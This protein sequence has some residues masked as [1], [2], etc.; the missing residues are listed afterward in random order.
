[1]FVTGDTLDEEA[2]IFL[3]KTRALCIGK[4]FVPEEITSVVRKAALRPIAS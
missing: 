4:P 1:V 3:K 2:R